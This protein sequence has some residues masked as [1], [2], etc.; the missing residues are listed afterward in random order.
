MKSILIFVHIPRTG[1]TSFRKVLEDNFSKDSIL[2][3][4][5]DDILRARSVVCSHTSLDTISVIRG[6]FSFGLHELIGERPYQYVTIIRHPVSRVMS[7]YNYIRS[8]QMHPMHSPVMSMS[9]LDFVTSGISLETDNGQVRQL[10]GTEG[11]FP[12]S[13]YGSMSTDFGKID[14]SQLEAALFNLCDTRAL[15]G[16]T[17]Q[18]G[19]FSLL[20]SSWFGFPIQRYPHVN[21]ASGIGR[22]D[23]ALDTLWKILAFNQYD[24]KLW[25]MA[26][27]Y[28]GV[29]K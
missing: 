5:G 6:H 8:D 3:I 27:L 22:K 11:E 12:Q 29:C 14:E 7:L 16:T 17:E 28:W 2:S 1:G 20:V 19:T 23:V 21:R 26:Q 13:C 10:C 4:Y 9:L 24:L 25:E 18:M 15:V